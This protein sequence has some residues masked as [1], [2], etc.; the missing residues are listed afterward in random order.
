M[1]W[2]T[3]QL[4]ERIKNIFMTSCGVIHRIN[5]Y[6]K[7]AEC[8]KDL[9][10]TIFFVCKKKGKVRIHMCLLV[11][12]RKERTNQKLLVIGHLPGGVGIWWKE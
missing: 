3:M 12:K 4:Y 8:K 5:D 2:N 9:S 7:K 1:Q 10:F 6:V 11:H